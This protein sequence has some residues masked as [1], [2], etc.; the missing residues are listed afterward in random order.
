M[1]FVILKALT[2]SPSKNKSPRSLGARE[3]LF[4]RFIYIRSC[5]I[6]GIN[7]MPQLFLINIRLRIFWIIRIL[8]IL[9]IQIS[10]MHTNPKENRPFF[11]EILFEQF[12][13]KGYICEEIKNENSTIF[14]VK[15]GKKIIG[16]LLH[17]TN[18]AYNDLSRDNWPC[19]HMR[20]KAA[21]GGLF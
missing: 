12:R 2:Y 16:P 15:H 6:R 8:L 3:A 21:F 13:R 19:V 7:F 20:N 10:Y 17:T 18:E 1:L 4:I 14:I 9:I 11:N 5:R